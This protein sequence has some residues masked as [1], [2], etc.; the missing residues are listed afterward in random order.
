M[1]QELKNNLK[2][3]IEARTVEYYE[4]LSDS[5]V[6]EAKENDLN[7]DEVTRECEQIIRE[8]CYFYYILCTRLKMFGCFIKGNGRIWRKKMC[9]R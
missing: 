2:E 3:F 5:I 9:F 6:N 1:I 7:Y 4:G 8:V